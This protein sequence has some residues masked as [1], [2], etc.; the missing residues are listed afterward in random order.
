MQSTLVRSSPVVVHISFNDMRI[1]I[2]HTRVCPQIQSVVSVD[3]CYSCPLAAKLVLRAKSICS[4]GMASVSFNNIP[5][6]SRAV[7]LSSDTSLV[8]IQFFTSTP[9]HDERV[10]LFYNEIKS[11]DIVSFCLV[12]P[13]LS[14]PQL[15]ASSAQSTALIHSSGLFDSIISTTTSLGTTIKTSIY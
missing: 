3:G 14:L 15:N 9:C 6:S 7:K 13:R 8:A 10:C 2:S 4:P 5:L 12:A 11:C 1:S